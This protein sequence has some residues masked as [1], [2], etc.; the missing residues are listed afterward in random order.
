[1]KSLN[2]IVCI[3]ML[4]LGLI[5]TTGMAVAKDHSP[6][7]VYTMT[8]AT[9]GNAILIFDRAAD[10]TLKPAGSALTGGVGTGGGLGNQSG[11]TLTENGQWLLAVNAGSDEISV[12]AVGPD[13]LIQVDKIWSGGVRPI[14]IATYKNLVYVLN[15]GGMENDE[16]NITGFMLDETGSLTQLP[17]STRSLSTSSTAPAQIGFN[18]N[19]TILVVTEKATGKINTFTLG[20]DGTVSNHQIFASAGTT[21]FGFSFGHRNHLFVSEANGGS[22]NASSVTSY[23]LMADGGLGVISPSVPTLQTAACWLA[24]TQN[25]KYAYT[26]NTGSDSTTGFVINNDGSLQ[27]LQEDGVSG[28]TGDAPIDMAFSRNS[29][30]LYVLNANETSITGFALNSSGQLTPVDV[31]NTLPGSANGLAAL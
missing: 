25:G 19:G 5:L 10:G 3:V 14:S 27:L 17:D 7:A 23:E 29:R 26:T 2:K 9:E 30:F 8:N 11:L 20:A 22:P 28:M 1:M 21:P 24:V 4:T 18:S 31:M 16:D 6:G 12:L 13:G 15:A